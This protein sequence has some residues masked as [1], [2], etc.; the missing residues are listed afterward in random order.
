MAAGEI[1]F[2]R[3]AFGG[4]AVRE[5]DGT[6]GGGPHRPSGY[7]DLEAIVHQPLLIPPG[8]PGRAWRPIPASSHTVRERSGC[9]LWDDGPGTLL[10]AKRRARA[11]ARDPPPARGRRSPVSP[12]IP[13]G[14]ADPRRRRAD[15]R[16]MKAGTLDARRARLAVDDLAVLP[17]RRAPPMMICC[18]SRASLPCLAVMECRPGCQ[19]RPDYG[20]PFP[21]V[22]ESRETRRSSTRAAGMRSC[23]R[24]S[25]AIARTSAVVGRF[26]SRARGHSPAYRTAATSAA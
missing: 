25:R 4:P 11:D 16:Q 2:N 21:A 26:T 18:W 9:H 22:D 19:G 1:G 23:S 6:A 12:G 15:R 8:N 3:D 24:A 13:A 20:E 14:P 17:A 10:D 5:A 7:C